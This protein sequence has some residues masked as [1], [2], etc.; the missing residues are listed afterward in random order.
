MNIKQKI[1]ILT[2]IFTAFGLSSLYSADS[3]SAL[4][5]WG[6]VVRNKCS[7]SADSIERCADVLAGKLAK[8]CGQAK[9]GNAYTK[10]WRSFISANGVKPGNAKPLN[11]P[12]P[13]SSSSDSKNNSGSNK[14]ADVDTAIIKCSASGKGKNLENNG[15][16]ALLVMLIKIM[17]AGVGILAVAGLGYGAFL[18]TTAGGSAAQIVKAKET[19]FN[20]V[21][22]IV[23]F[24]LMGA[25]LQFLIPGGVF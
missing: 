24:A 19:I 5:P 10:C 4:D 21:V 9:Q 2:L 18:W 11:I 20:V 12:K 16:W 7:G 22:G 3:V 17:T 13:G 8:K 23:A 6:K 14:C 25:L 15:V 1:V